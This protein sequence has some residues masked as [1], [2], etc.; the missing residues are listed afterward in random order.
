M[1]NNE[2][3]AEPRCPLCFSQASEIFFY[4]PTTFNQ[5]IFNYYECKQCNCAYIHPFPGK[6]DLDLIYGEED[7]AYLKKTGENEMHIHNFEIPLY[8]HQRYQIDFFSKYNYSLTAKNLLDIGCGSGFYMSYARQS[9]LEVTGIEYNEEFTALLRKKTGLSVFSFDEFEK[10][11]NGKKF[12]LIHFGHILEH[13]S[14]PHEML[15]WV[16][17]YTHENSIII[18]D[19]PL[20]KNTCLSNF[21]ISTGSKIRKNK[22]NFYAPQ[23]ISFTDYDSQL[24]FFEK[25]GLKKI[26]YFVAEQMFPLPAKPDYRSARNFL[27]FLTGRFSVT[28]SKFNSRWG[29]IFHY[30]GRF[31]T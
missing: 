10:N 29:N 22:M 6:S 30:A 23:H 25:C 26:N 19:G 27:L 14:A 18:I 9:G 13:L 11:N 28:I 20:E 3:I 16:K 12:D 7:H 24:R 1:K 31:H 21:V 15:E 2:Q 17:K 4:P 5:K 8:N